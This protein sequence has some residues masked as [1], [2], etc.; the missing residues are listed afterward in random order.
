MSDVA[1]RNHDKKILIAVI[2][3]NEEKNIPIVLENLRQHNFGYDVILIDNGSYDD[4]SK[5]GQK[6]GVK[7]VVHCVNSGSSAGTLMS[8]FLY[9]YRYGYDIVCQFDGDGQHLAEE[10]PK[11]ITPVLEGRAD[12]V[13]GSRFIKREGF[14]STSIR[15]LGIWLFGK[16]DS[17]ILGMPVTDVTSGFR[18]YGRRVIEFFG[19]YY[20]H[21]VY[22]TSQLL[23]LSHFS[24]ARVLEVPVRMRERIHGTSEFTPLTSIGFVIK[25]LVNVIGCLMQRK[26]IRKMVETGYGH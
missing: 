26:Q 8:Y 6:F 17:L 3:Y 13:V 16:I 11:I 18:A 22:D 20:K 9:A 15:R 25:G 12:Y 21:E 10:L 14:Q 19:K 2:A 1:S 23:L 4:T 5:M 7:T 24:G